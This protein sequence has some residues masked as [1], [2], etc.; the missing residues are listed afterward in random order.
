MKTKFHREKIFYSYKH[1]KSR[2][3]MT[4][5]IGNIEIKIKNFK[6]TYMYRVEIFSFLPQR[7]I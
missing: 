6:Y 5:Y 3:I 7:S 4:A 2:S 1:M